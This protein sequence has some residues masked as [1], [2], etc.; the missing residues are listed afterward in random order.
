VGDFSGGVDPGHA[1]EVVERAEL[2]VI[3]LERPTSFYSDDTSFRTSNRIGDI[4]A[5]DSQFFMKSEWGSVSA[6]WP[7]FSFPNRSAAD[8]LRR[9]FRLTRNFIVYAGTSSADR[10]KA[11]EHRRSTISIVVTEPGDPIP[12]EKLVPWNS[13]Q[14]VLAEH[15][16]VWPCSF[17][18]VRGRLCQDFPKADE[19]THEAYRALDFRNNWGSVVEV[20]GAE[21]EPLFHRGLDGW[22]FR[23]GSDAR[24]GRKAKPRSYAPGESRLESGGDTNGLINSRANRLW[25]H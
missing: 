10:T 6:F 23:I 20:L 3:P 12:T 5:V 25:P 9:E 1:N 2:K 8:L 16:M 17:G 4:A 13:W 15:G 14:A 19:L 11:E 7:A 21:R 22:I 18:V 24:S